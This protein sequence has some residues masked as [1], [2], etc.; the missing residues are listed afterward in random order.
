MTVLNRPNHRHV[1]TYQDELPKMPSWRAGVVTL[2]A[3]AFLSGC[4]QGRG[5]WPT[6]SSALGWGGD[7]VPAPEV[8]VVAPA[9]APVRSVALQGAPNMMAWTPPPAP[10]LTMQTIQTIQS[11]AP[12]PI[13]LTPVSTN[14]SYGSGNDLVAQAFSDGIA[15]TSPSVLTAPAGL[16]FASAAAQPLSE[17]L[18]GIVPRVVLDTHN[19]SLSESG[20]DGSQSAMT[21]ADSGLEYLD[22]VVIKFRRG[23]SRLS[24]RD[25]RRIGRIVKDY[26]SKGGKIFVVGHASSRTGDMKKALHDTVNFDISLDRANIVTSE[27]LIQG[28]LPDHLMMEAR[29]DHDP[30]FY[31]YMP[32]GEA[33]NQRVEIFHE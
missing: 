29:A 2:M 15:A 26:R 9:S 12:P 22:P 4:A 19:Q 24:P 3:F 5:D 33:G 17:D 16:Q 30:I 27:L 8:E 21:M 13:P 10:P 25:K 23:S 6:L 28:V 18:S 14:Y 31:E 7:S 11:I 32:L 20:P 1:E